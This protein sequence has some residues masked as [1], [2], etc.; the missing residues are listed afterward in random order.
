[1]A[2]T[3][4]KVVRSLHSSAPKGGYPRAQRPTKIHILPP[5]PPTM[6]SQRSPSL[7]SSSTRTHEVAPRS[8]CKEWHCDLRIT[9]SPSYAGRGTWNS[10]NSKAWA[11]RNESAL[12]R[13]S[14]LHAHELGGAR[15]I[16][17]N[18]SSLKSHILGGWNW[19]SR[20]TKVS[21]SFRRITL[22]YDQ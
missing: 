5:V 13:L 16:W 21:I 4:L 19:S 20:L 2:A 6:R 18:K 1:M 15:E 22:D 7:S 3:H 11:E 17:I 14:P 8:S 10:L 12:T 9:H